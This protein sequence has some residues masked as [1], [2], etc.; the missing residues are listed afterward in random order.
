MLVLLVVCARAFSLYLDILVTITRA[1]VWLDAG[2]HDSAW[3][4]KDEADMLTSMNVNKTIK[5]QK[6]E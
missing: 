2:S 1:F 5:T 6:T 4:T 3:V